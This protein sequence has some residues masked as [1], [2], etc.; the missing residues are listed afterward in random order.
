[1]ANYGFVYVLGNDYMPGIYKIGMTNQTPLRRRDE[2]SSG[3]A[4]PTP[5]NLLFYIEVDNAA[6]VERTI[7]ECLQADRISEGREFFHCDIRKIHFEF[8][9]WEADGAPMATT[10]FGKEALYGKDFTDQPV[11]N[12]EP[13]NEA[14]GVI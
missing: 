8:S 6:Q 4:V 2:L 14:V 11:P 5:F 3:T 12:T 1:M 7:H 13:I 10:S 9:Q